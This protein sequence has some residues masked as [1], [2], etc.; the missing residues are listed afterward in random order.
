MLSAEDNETIT[1]TG[2]GT[3]M[4]KLMRQF[5]TPAI[6]S[7]RLVADAAPERVRLLGQDFVAFRA[8]NGQAGFFDE[9]CPHR[10]VSLSLARNE[11]GELKCIY[12][13]WK[14]HVSGKVAE[15]PTEPAA[16]REAFAQRVRLRHYPVREA[17]G[18]LWV[19]LGDGV[20]AEFPRLNWLDLPPEQLRVRLGVIPCNWLQ[21]LEGQLDSAHV[22]VLHQDQINP[23]K[24]SDNI[25]KVAFDSAPRFDFEV[26]PYGFREAALRSLPDGS[27]YA[28]VREFVMP[29]YSYIPR[30]AR[31][32]RQHLT[33]AVP[34]DD[35]TSAQWDV[36]YNLEAP[37]TLEDLGVDFDVNPD[38]CAVG[39]GSI[40]NRFGQN[41]EAMSS[42]SSFSGF[43]SIRFEDFAVNSAQGPIAD[44]TI[45]NLSSSDLPIVRTRRML[46]QAAR[47]AARGELAMPD[48]STVDWSAIRAV[49]EVMPAGGEWRALPR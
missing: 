22:G 44:R 3:A 13:G 6:R 25:G 27:Q 47:S 40:D 19:W 21:G 26:M 33:I 18:I 41:R 1:R 42:G 9:R 46:L 43:S 12:H 10:G 14:F 49:D 17:G 4:G 7:A 16:T 38:D 37:L 2:P 31:N 15:V 24:R 28:R 29:Y 34:V 36:Y 39:L 5:W 32:E 45:E 23:Q 35:T 30:G 20:P 11:N 8:S 48:A